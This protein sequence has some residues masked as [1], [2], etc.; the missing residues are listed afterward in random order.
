MR[1]ARCGSRSDESDSF[2]RRC[3]S[4]LS[5]EGAPTIVS[6]SL[7]P[8]PWGLVRN[9]VGK[10][11][12]AVAAGT[13]VELLR[14]ELIRRIATTAATEVLPALVPESFPS[15]RKGRFPWSRPREHYEVTV[16]VVQRTVRL[17]R[18]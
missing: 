5:R 1:C 8:A 7:L 11:L 17:F 6:S 14:R 12:V 13:A 10:G 15:P 18:R 16:T 2:C 3:G 9:S 4:K